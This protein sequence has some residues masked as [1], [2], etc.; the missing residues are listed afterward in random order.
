MK[1]L[2][3]DPGTVQSGW[4]IYDTKKPDDPIDVSQTVREVTGKAAKMMDI[5]EN[6]GLRFIIL[7][8]KLWDEFVIE[9][10]ESYG[11]KHQIGKETIRTIEWIGRFEECAA[12]RYWSMHRLTS[13]DVRLHL[14]GYMGADKPAI[15]RALLDRFGPQG[16]KKKPGVLYGVREH[17]WSALALAVVFADRAEGIVWKP[18]K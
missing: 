13:R 6:N 14:C 7:D 9:E 11:P 3:I 17:I 15:R 5:V 16:T 1:I 10:I 8:K 4:V 12:Q 2:A 18:K